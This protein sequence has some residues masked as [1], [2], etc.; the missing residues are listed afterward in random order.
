MSK[1]DKD[2]QCYLL[3]GLRLGLGRGI[4]SREFLG[5]GGTW[6]NTDKTRRE[7]SVSVFIRVPPRPI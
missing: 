7:N 6:M 4:F 2:G 5:H 1:I 3:L